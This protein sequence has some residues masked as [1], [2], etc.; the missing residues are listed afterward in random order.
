MHLPCLRKGVTVSLSQLKPSIHCLFSENRCWATYA[1]VAE[2]H[3]AGFA[4]AEEKKTAIVQEER[5]AGAIFSPAAH[6]TGVLRLCKEIHRY[7]YIY[8][9]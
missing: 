6:F 9:K 5:G 7:V 8:E 2:A 4:F 1:L 3:G